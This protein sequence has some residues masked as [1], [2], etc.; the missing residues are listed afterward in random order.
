MLIAQA[1]MLMQA[2]CNTHSDFPMKKSASEDEISH[3]L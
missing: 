3:I 2:F 1:T